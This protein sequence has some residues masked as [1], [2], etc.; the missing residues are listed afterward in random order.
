MKSARVGLFL[1]FKAIAS[2]GCG[3]LLVIRLVPLGNDDLTDAG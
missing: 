2:Y 1:G 3:Y